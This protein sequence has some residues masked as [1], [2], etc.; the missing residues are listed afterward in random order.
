[1]EERMNKVFRDKRKNV[2]F[3]SSR[4]RLFYN[5]TDLGKK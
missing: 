2:V 3:L 4:D 1:M 5:L